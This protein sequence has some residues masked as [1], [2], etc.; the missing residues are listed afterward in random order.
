MQRH[1]V[2]IDRGRE[3]L[4]KRELPREVQSHDVVALKVAVPNRK[5]CDETR[6][7]DRE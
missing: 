4:P 6:V 1:E 5:I 3:V 7:H 2:H